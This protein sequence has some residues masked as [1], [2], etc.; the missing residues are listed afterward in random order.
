MTKLLALVLIF[1]ILVGNSVIVLVFGYGLVPQ[2]WWVIVG[3]GVFGQIAAKA[4]L[5]AVLKEKK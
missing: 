2:N 1:A 4:M 5:D 3:F